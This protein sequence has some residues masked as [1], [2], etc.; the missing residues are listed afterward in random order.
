LRD[1]HASGRCEKKG[2]RGD[3]EAYLQPGDE[4]HGRSEKAAE[5]RDRHRPANLPERVENGTGGP[6][7]LPGTLARTTGVI[8]GMAVAPPTPFRIINLATSGGDPRGR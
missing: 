7:C 1:E 3:T 4:T 8:G 6:A 5:N 2:K